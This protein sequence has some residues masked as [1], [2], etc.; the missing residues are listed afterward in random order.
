MRRII[1]LARFPLAVIL[2]LGSVLAPHAQA[3]LPPRSARVFGDP[4]R[5]APFAPTLLPSTSGSPVDCVILTPDSLADVFQKLADYQTRSGRPTVVRGL[6]TVRA[7]DPR[8]N[9]MAQAVRS[10]LKSA[11]DLWGIRWAVL[12]A[13][14]EAIPLRTVRVNFGYPEDLPTDVYYSDL[15]GT[16]DRNGNG[17][18]GEVADSLDMQPDI[19]VGRLSAGTRAEATILV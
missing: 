9:D 11:H 1:P 4:G 10:F 15:D 6:S 3:G 18:Y 2:V 16:W 13:D 14:H 19:A 7:A 8:S 17:V 5:A 12:G